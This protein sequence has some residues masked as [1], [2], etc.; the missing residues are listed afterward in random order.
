MYIPYCVLKLHVLSKT[1]R[2]V[3][4][5]IKQ[6]FHYKKMYFKSHKTPYKTPCKDTFHLLY[7]FILHF[8]G[9]SPLKKH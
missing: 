1:P 9:N 8:R 4:V 2:Q 3:Q 7:M 6:I 5:R